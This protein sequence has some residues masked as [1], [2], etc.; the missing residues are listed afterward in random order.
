M[1]DDAFII[2]V[3]ASKSSLLITFIPAW[4]LGRPGE[5]V[6]GVAGQPC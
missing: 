4:L 2:L 1:F 5:E 3:A 6:D